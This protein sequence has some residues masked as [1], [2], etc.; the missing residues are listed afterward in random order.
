M[1]TARR[2][3]TYGGW[4]IL[5]GAAASSFYSIGKWPSNFFQPIFIGGVIGATIY[6][7][8]S[9]TD[10]VLGRYALAPRVYA[11]ARAFALV[12]S[13]I[14]GSVVGLWIG[15]HL[16][17]D[18]ITFAEMFTGH[19][20]I[21]VVMATIISA[22]SA[23]VVRSYDLLKVRL[24]TALVRIKEQEWTEKEL[25]LARAVQTRLLPPTLVT[26][27][28]FSIASRNLP[29]HLVAGDFYDVVRLDDGSVFVVIA[30]VAGK[31]MA[32]SLIMASVKAVLPFLAREGVRQVMSRL[33]EKLIEE[34]ARRE[35]VALACA[36][37]DPKTGTVEIANGGCPD[38]YLVTS[39][40]VTTIAP[41][42]PR[43]PLGVRAGIAYE[44]TR[45]QIEPGDRLLLV[46]DG[47]PEAP[48]TNGEPLGYDVLARIV[49]GLRG[50]DRTAESWLDDF[51]AT[52]RTHV[53][54]GYED[55]WTAVV[56]ER[57]EMTG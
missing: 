45:L 46:T 34:L 18:E 7:A 16:L 47:I 15:V 51:L 53:A 37:F 42:G 43:L 29:A 19:G 21:F 30:D 41:P 44:S 2:H 49:S 54:E 20:R 57:R 6:G 24:S 56:V 14:V 17:G 55:D 38:P 28:G 35:F 5:I 39:H 13:G 48:M 1:R 52:V 22:L 9:L 40:G 26:G 50:A 8:I 32:A 3:L 27:Q 23:I 12:A 36:R 11:L 10:A 31:G 33:N 25:A 4:A